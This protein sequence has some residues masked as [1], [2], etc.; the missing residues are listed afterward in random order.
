V[1]LFSF[2]GLGPEPGIQAQTASKLA[3]QGNALAEQRKQGRYR[4]V[5]TTARTTSLGRVHKKPNQGEMDDCK[6]K[7]DYFV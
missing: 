7:S 1:G 2:Q 5:P 3:G 6:I 4:R